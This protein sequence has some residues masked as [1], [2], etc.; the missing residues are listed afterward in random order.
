MNPDTH[1][2][3]MRLLEA[4][5]GVSQRDMSRALGVS[6]GKIN[7]CLRTLI[8]N[9]W[10]NVKDISDGRNKAAYMYLITPLGTEQKA[11][12][13]RRFLQSKMSEYEALRAEIAQLRREAEA[14]LSIQTRKLSSTTGVG[15][16]E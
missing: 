12:L 2:K 7:Y 3:L 1:Y 15:G 4:D 13:A 5:P 9:G 8:N 10:I 11:R 6:L 16:K 14:S